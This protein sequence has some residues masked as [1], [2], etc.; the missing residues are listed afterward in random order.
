[1]TTFTARL[2]DGRLHLHEGPIDLVIMADGAPDEIEAAYRQATRRF[3]GLLQSIVDDLPALRRP[4][5]DA[6]SGVRGSIGRR[7]AAAVRPHGTVFITPM[8]AVAGSVADEMLAALIAGRD[9]P[10]AYVNNGGDIAIH[11]APGQSLRIGVVASDR[12][13]GLAGI[14]T[15]DAAAPVR[16]I[17]TSGFGGR[18]QTLGIADAATVL[19]RD[20]ATA[21]AAATLVANAIDIDHPAIR[22]LPARAVK[23]DSDLGDIPVTV[24][25]GPLEPEAVARALDNGATEAERLRRAGHLVAAMLVLRG[26]T[27]VIGEAGL[28]GHE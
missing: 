5:G 19:A 1:M 12:R 21:D 24:A 4:V 9:L 10:R 18:S 8:A 3:D 16:G 28:I 22:R 25:V 23:D 15:V 27:R 13:P 17:A 26:S 2:P 11:L 20:A 6:P 14:A 7:M